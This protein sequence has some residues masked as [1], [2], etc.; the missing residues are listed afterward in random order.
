MTSD[1]VKDV[2]VWGA[3]GLFFEPENVAVGAFEDFLVFVEEDGVVVAGFFGLFVGKVGV[4]VGGGFD[5]G[6]AADA[7]GGGA[8]NAFGL[9]AWFFGELGGDD[10]D[11]VLN[12]DDFETLEFVG[13]FLD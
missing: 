10:D 12:G 9:E 6:K 7:V 4:E 3:E 11:V 8:F 1:A 13:G 5:L 2:F